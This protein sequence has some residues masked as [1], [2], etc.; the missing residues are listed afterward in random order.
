[1]GKGGEGVTRDDR[2]E[3]GDE[4]KRGQEG[5]EGGGKILAGG[6]TKGPTKGSGRVPC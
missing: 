3:G 6:R 1:M 4:G 5:G 2:T